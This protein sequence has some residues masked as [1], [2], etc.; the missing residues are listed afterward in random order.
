MLAAPEPRPQ[1]R[2]GAG[3]DRLDDQEVVREALVADDA[4]LALQSRATSG[5]GI[6][7]VA[8]Q[9]PRLAARLQDL[10][11][12]AALERIGREDGLPH[13]PVHRASSPS[14]AAFS[15]ASGACESR[16][17]IFGGSQ[18]GALRLGQGRR[19]APRSNVVLPRDGAQRVVD[20]VPRAMHE[21]DVVGR[22]GRDSLLA[23]PAEEWAI[24]AARHDLG[25]DRKRAA[26]RGEKIALGAEEDQ[27]VRVRPDRALER[28]RRIQMARGEHVA[29]G[30]VPLASLREEHRLHGRGPGLHDL[31]SRDRREPHSSQICR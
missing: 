23:R 17:S 21:V 29:E 31:G 2:G 30:A 7:S 10:E 22:D 3:C 11:R 13:R 6:A 14:R 18:E 8:V 27:G 26:Q 24:L 28:E 1:M 4:E 9:D 15:S 16:A 20:A 5:I 12:L 25:V 19:A